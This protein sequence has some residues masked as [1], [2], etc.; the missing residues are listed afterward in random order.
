MES[1]QFIADK[2]IHTISDEY[3]FISSGEGFLFLGDDKGRVDCYSVTVS[4]IE[5]ETKTMN[6][7]TGPMDYPF[8]H[9]DEIPFGNF[10][11]D[12]YGDS[13]QSPFGN[14]K[15]N[16]YNHSNQSPSEFCLR[17][18][19][20]EAKSKMVLEQEK[21][22]E[23]ERL[24]FNCTMGLGLFGNVLPNRIPN[25][26]KKV[27]SNR[28]QFDKGTVIDNP[29][30]ILNE[31]SPEPKIES[32]AGTTITSVN[33]PPYLRNVSESIQSTSEVGHNP[34]HVPDSSLHISSYGTTRQ[35]KPRSI[36][37]GRIPAFL[38]TDIK[39]NQLQRK[40]TGMICSPNAGSQNDEIETFGS[41]LSV[42]QTLTP[43]L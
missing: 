5:N 42:S 25:M 18:I 4:E 23:E 31:L 3:S 1:R 7:S 16:P 34:I 39:R 20:E 40:S 36:Q 19:L 27:C 30:D 6:S 15:N 38:S 13:N 32:N 12:P 2:G 41:N 43:F 9:F 33:N 24:L 29:A 35:N 10:K 26:H 21:Q 17:N 14:S 11:D 28:S 37:H 22:N 8:G